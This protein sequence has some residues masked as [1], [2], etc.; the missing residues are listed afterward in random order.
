MANK[1]TFANEFVLSKTIN[2]YDKRIYPLSAVLSL[3]LIDFPEARLSNVEPI[4]YTV[5]RVGDFTEESRIVL[6]EGG[7]I[8]KGDL[9]DIVSELPRN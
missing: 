6:A 3:Y 5:S 7:K 4:V 2:R 1:W 8:R 9:S